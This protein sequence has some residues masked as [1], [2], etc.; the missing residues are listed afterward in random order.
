M[1]MMT[2]M[3]INNKP[4]DVP[5]KHARVAVVH[6]PRHFDGECVAGRRVVSRCYLPQ[7]ECSLAP[8]WQVRHLALSPPCSEMNRHVLSF[9]KPI[10]LDVSRFSV[11]TINLSL[12]NNNN[13][14]VLFCRYLNIHCICPHKKI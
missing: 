10:I 8:R 9:V 13:N 12:A 11:A 1:M 5:T 4:K 3:I 7:S 6:S 2:I 14:N